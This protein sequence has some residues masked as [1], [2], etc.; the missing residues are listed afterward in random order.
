[1]ARKLR[2]V[3]KDLDTNALSMILLPCVGG[4]VMFFGQR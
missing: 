1:M 3:D 2:S 4:M